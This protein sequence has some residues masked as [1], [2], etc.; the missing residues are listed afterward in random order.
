MAVKK[1]KTKRAKAKSAPHDPAK[2]YLN[3]RWEG[4][5]QDVLAGVSQADAYRKHYP[6]CKVWKASSIHEAASR[7]ASK[8]ASRVEWLK[9]QAAGETIDYAKEIIAMHWESALECRRAMEEFSKDGHLHVTQDAIDRRAQAVESLEEDERVVG[10]GENARVL[11]KQKL[12]LRDYKEYTDRIA[13]MLGLNAPEK[14]DLRVEGNI[15]TI[16]REIHEDDEPD[17][18]AA[19]Q[20]GGAGCLTTT[21][22]FSSAT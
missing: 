21:K 11:K 9:K 22:S 20:K 19:T 7:L 10:M 16:L 1:R 5:A 18:A 6:H 13:R 8:V 3:A 4:F 12:K 15:D 14:R 17:A 2:P